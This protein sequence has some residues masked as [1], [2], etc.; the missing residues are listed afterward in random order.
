[1]YVIFFKSWKLQQWLVIYGIRELVGYACNVFHN[2]WIIGFLQLH[3]HFEKLWGA[4]MVAAGC[5][6]AHVSQ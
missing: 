2:C 4:K 6:Y 5:M 1:M 3:Q